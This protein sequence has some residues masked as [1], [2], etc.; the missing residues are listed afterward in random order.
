MAKG[1]KWPSVLTI[2]VDCVVKVSNFVIPNILASAVIP[3]SHLQKTQN[4]AHFLKNNCNLL[5]LI[6]LRL[7][8]M[9]HLFIYDPIFQNHRV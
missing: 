9:Y 2:L 1:H 3:T 7:P 4:S 6:T 8:K 5:R